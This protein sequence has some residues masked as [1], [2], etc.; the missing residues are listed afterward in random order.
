RTARRRPAKAYDIP[1]V[2]P[3]EPTRLGEVT[4]LEPF[5]DVLLEGALE[6]P[7]GPEVHYEQTES[8]SL[9]FVTALQVLP[10]RQLAVLIL[11]DILGFAAS[12][13]ADMLDSTVDSVNS[14]L[15]RA[16]ANLESR[17]P[18]AVDRQ[19]VTGPR[20]SPSASPPVTPSIS[21]DGELVKRFV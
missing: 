8:I 12:E 4:W 1:G 13:V 3:P 20:R 18:Q 17:R 6:P 19:P 7:P 11:C 9:T 14:A 21:S 5:P 10:H 15:K 2:T 16:R